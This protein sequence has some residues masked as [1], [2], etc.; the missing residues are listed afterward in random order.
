MSHVCE[1]THEHDHA[2]KAPDKATRLSDAEAL[3]AAA[4]ERMTSVA[5]AHLRTDPRSRR[6]DQGL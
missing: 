1:H 6:A 2:L 3:C 4:G 5:P